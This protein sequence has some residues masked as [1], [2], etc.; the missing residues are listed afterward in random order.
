MGA[1]KVL[2]EFRGPVGL[3]YG[4]RNL[5]R[6]PGAFFFDAGLAKNFPIIAEKLNLQ[7][8]ADAFNL[9]NHP[10][11]GMPALDIVNNAS[12]FGQIT[13]TNASPASSAVSADDARVAQFS[14]RLEF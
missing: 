13:S 8:R 10:N 3:E 5:V 12:N 7:F 11:F 9:F 1:A 4:Q 14:L 2:A 6:G